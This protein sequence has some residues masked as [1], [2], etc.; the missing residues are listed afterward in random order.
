MS[1]KT[2]LF[3]NRIADFSNLRP[4]AACF[5]FGRTF[6]LR[7]HIPLAAVAVAEGEK[8]SALAEDLRPLADLC[9]QHTKRIV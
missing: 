9:N 6:G 1:F 7:L 3:S 8:P 5:T 4:L 2:Q